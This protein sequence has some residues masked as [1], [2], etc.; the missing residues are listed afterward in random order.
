[1]IQKFYIGQQ[2]KID[3]PVREFTTPYDTGTI[4]DF[5]PKFLAMQTTKK[6]PYD[7]ND[8][9]FLIKFENNKTGIFRRSELEPLI[10]DFDYSSFGD[11]L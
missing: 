7:Q 5:Y 8:D 4:V 9:G 1:M 6:L 10:K 3:C 11:P 2:V